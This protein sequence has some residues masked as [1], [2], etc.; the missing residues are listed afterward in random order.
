MNNNPGI[1]QI[2]KVFLSEIIL[3]RESYIP[4]LLPF[5]YFMLRTFSV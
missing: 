1:L 5:I 3:C 4:A 2:C